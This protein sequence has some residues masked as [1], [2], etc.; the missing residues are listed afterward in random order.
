MEGYYGNRLHH[1]LWRVTMA[2]GCTIIY[3][4]L[5]WRQ[6]LPGIYTHLQTGHFHVPRSQL[7]CRYD[8]R[9]KHCNK[10]HKDITRMLLLIPYKIFKIRNINKYFFLRIRMRTNNFILNMI[11]PILHDI[12]ISIK[13]EIYR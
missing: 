10:T 11:S 12:V 7:S 1:N 8:S 3:G 13:R 9:S 4:G 6:A 5:L 2:T